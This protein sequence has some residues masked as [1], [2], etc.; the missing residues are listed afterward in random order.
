VGLSVEWVFGVD[1]SAGIGSNGAT[2]VGCCVA[3]V[4]SWCFFLSF[5]WFQYMFHT[6][7]AGEQQQ[8]CSFLT[9]Q[10]E[11]KHQQERSHNISSNKFRNPRKKKP[12][13]IHKKKDVVIG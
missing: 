9:L 5:C 6:I 11:K 12:M 7:K 13:I 10:G 2:V 4:F 8:H 3:L 1:A